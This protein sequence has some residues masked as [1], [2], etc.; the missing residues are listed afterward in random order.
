MC[1]CLCHLFYIE[2]EINNMDNLD[3]LLKDCNFR[4][5]EQLVPHLKDRMILRK[6]YN[7]Y[8]SFI[9]ISFKLRDT[10]FLCIY[11]IIIVHLLL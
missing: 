9:F 5:F 11:M 3:D 1:V 4:D 7:E 8:V 6:K 10:K 2:N